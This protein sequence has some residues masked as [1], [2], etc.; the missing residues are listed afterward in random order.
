M[1]VNLVVISS[2]FWFASRRKLMFRCAPSVGAT[3]H[4]GWCRGWR[5]SSKVVDTT[6]QTTLARV[7]EAPRTS[8]ATTRGPMA[9]RKRNHRLTP[10]RRRAGVTHRAAAHR[11][12][13]HRAAAHRA[14]A[15]RAAAHGA[16]THRAEIHRT[17]SLHTTPIPPQHTRRLQPLNSLT[18]KIPSKHR[19]TEDESARCSYWLHEYSQEQTR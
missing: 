2:V 18:G 19:F 16:E 11:A 3:R 5:S 14:A 6:R 7:V 8:E 13:A 4:G 1:S 15:H 17:Q 10:S 12:A 9:L